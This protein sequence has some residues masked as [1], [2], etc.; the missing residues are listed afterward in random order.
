MLA[1]ADVDINGM[2]AMDGRDWLGRN[3]RGVA[4]RVQRL[5]V[6]WRVLL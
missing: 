3:G 4:L 6:N 5:K 2:A 1:A